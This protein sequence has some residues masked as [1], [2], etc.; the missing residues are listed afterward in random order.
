MYPLTCPSNL[1]FASILSFGTHPLLTKILCLNKSI[2][3][4]D[5]ETAFRIHF[6]HANLSK[7]VILSNK[8]RSEVKLYKCQENS[9]C[10]GDSPT[11]CYLKWRDYVSTRFWPPSQATTRMF[12]LI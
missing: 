11:L 3:N 2:Q 4:A 12:T 9:K 7:F 1:F 8:L 10:F 5:D 6:L